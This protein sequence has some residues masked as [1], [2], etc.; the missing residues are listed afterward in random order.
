MWL[1]SSNILLKSLVFQKKAKNGTVTIAIT[2]DGAKIEGKLC[3]VTIEFKI[4]DVD[5]FNPKTGKKVMR[6]MQSN[7][8]CF[9]VMRIIAKYNKNTYKKYFDYI[10]DFC[11][12][13]RANGWTTKDGTQWNPFIV[14]D[15]QDMKSHQLFLGVDGACKGPGVV[16]FCHLCSHTSDV[17]AV[18]NQIRCDI[19]VVKR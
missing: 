8:W 12:E 16:H 19:Y 18:P 17:V 14:P 7:Q 9:P 2:I 10:F 15:P 13:V 4:V 6:N 11:N 3:H 1:Q 5:A